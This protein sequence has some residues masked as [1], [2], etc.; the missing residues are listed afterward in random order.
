M[1]L[2]DNS[3]VFCREELFQAGKNGKRQGRKKTGQKTRL[4]TTQKPFPGGGSKTLAAAKNGVWN[5]KDDGI[6]GRS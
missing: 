2:A 6:M 5:V 1:N 3:W 4:M